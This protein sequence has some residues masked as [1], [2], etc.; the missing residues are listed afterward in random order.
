M[1]VIPPRFFSIL[2]LGGLLQLL[3]LSIASV[4]FFL[5]ESDAALWSALHARP[6]YVSMA[7][8]KLFTECKKKKKKKILWRRSLQHLPFLLLP[9]HHR[10]TCESAAWHTLHSFSSQVAR[11]VQKESQTGDCQCCPAVSV[12]NWHTTHCLY[13]CCQSVLA[14][15]DSGVEGATASEN[16]CCN[17]YKYASNFSIVQQ[18]P[19][20]TS[21]F[22][23]IQLSQF[24]GQRSMPR[25]NKA[26]FN[27]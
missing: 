11:T 7:S 8:L 12:N 27:F 18:S 26:K 16:S 24:P 14:P 5:P 17:S 6:P 23:Y 3:L 21:V 2:L 19:A 4:F 22:V 25:Y 9:S 1:R 10:K 15:P 13:S 20:R